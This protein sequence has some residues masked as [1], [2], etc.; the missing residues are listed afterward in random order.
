MG[1]KRTKNHN[2][3]PRMHQKGNVY[4]YVASRGGKRVWERLSDVWSE[5][6][7]LY[8]QREGTNRRGETVADAIDRYL[9]EIAP[10]KAAKTCKEYQ[11]QGGRLRAAWQ[12]FRL[13]EVRPVH[14]AHYLD[15]HAYKVAANREIALLST[16]FAHAMRW[17]W[18]NQ[19][20]CKGVHRNEEEDRDR[21]IEDDE[22]SRLKESASDQY[23]CIIELAYLTAM[24]KS[25]ILKLK[26]SEPAAHAAAIS[27]QRSPTACVLIHTSP[28]DPV[29]RCG[30]RPPR[31]LRAAGT[32]RLLGS[33]RC[34]PALD[35]ERL[36]S[37]LGTACGRD[38]DL[39][40]P[41]NCRRTRFL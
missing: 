16:I 1:R 24:R 23:R 22:L 37:V 4:Y 20:P 5:A 40:T 13:D 2:L 19:N 31:R 36:P 28:I 3:P 14:I 34:S 25:D 15:S 10:L 6:L 8:A 27:Y 39:A 21:Y 7:A 26:L 33:R 29:F 35:R 32:T 41:P 30:V 12:E 11:R 17:G 18:C 38:D 9:V